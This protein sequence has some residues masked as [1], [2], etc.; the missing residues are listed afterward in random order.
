MSQINRLIASA[1]DLDDGD[2]IGGGLP[3]PQMRLDSTSPTKLHFINRPEGATV[4]VY[5]YTKN[6][7]GKHIKKIRW[8]RTY[9]VVA[10]STEQLNL[11]D[12]STEEH[13]DWNEAF[14]T[15]IDGVT[16]S[17][18]DIDK[19]ILY[20]DSISGTNQVYRIIAL[21][22]SLG[23]QYAVVSNTHMNPQNSAVVVSGGTVNANTIWLCVGTDPVEYQNNSVVNRTVYS[24]RIG[25]RYRLVTDAGAVNN[26]D[27]AG[28]FPRLGKVK[29]YRFAYVMNDATGP[30]SQ[31]MWLLHSEDISKWRF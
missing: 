7:A 8:N 3:S 26:W 22:E 21:A 20:K 18:G 16:F 25:K 23:V 24:D 6:R 5:K 2:S 15:P 31:T 17:E 10:A 30:M 4:A 1:A 14:A 12:F 19:C 9:T 11:A 28:V 13:P 27:A 29:A